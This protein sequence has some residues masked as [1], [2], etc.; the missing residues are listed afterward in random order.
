MTSKKNLTKFSLLGCLY[1]SQ[2]IPIAFF[3]QALPVFL[4]QQ[5]V[6]LNAIGLLPLISL[7]W[8]LKF[9]WSPL[10]DRYS[11]SEHQHYRPWIIG[12]QSLLALTLIA[13]AFLNI[14]QNPMAM[15]ISLFIVCFLAAT[16]D[17]A[18]DALAINLLSIEERGVGNGVQGAGNYLG[19]IIGGGGMLILLNRWGWQN[20]LLIMAMFTLL[21]TLPIWLHQEKTQTNLR[22]EKP[23]FK[24]LIKFCRRRGITSWLFILLTY[25]LGIR[26]ATFMFQPLLVDLGLSLEEI[27]LLTGIIGFSAAMVGAPIAGFLITPLGRKRSLIIFGILQSLAIALY[28]IPGMKIVNAPLLYLACIIVQ[29][30]FSMASTAKFTVMMDRSELDTAGT[31][32]TLQASF[33]TFSTIF[34]SGIAGVMAE[35]L[36]YVSLF[37]ISLVISLASVAL[38]AKT[39]AP[40]LSTQ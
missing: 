21:A 9:L 20:S 19:A 38:T 11:F 7:P 34:A 6:A 36:G 14:E 39:F 10:V 3:Y 32:Y 8:M 13:V 17:I 33:S 37:I 28:L 30:T 18:T 16:Q 29:M 5:G 12:C 26:M 27:G 25:S 24:A 4:R 1:V 31:D 35:A 2:Y 15:I 40:K 22:Q 23:N